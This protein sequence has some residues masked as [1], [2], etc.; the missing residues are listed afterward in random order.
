MVVRMVVALAVA[1]GWSMLTSGPGCSVGPDDFP[2]PLVEDDV[3]GCSVGPRD[4]PLGELA[5]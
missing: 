2:S 5:K 1:V 3:A 4:W